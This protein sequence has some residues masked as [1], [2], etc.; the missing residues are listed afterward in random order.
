[1]MLCLF[2]VVLIFGQSLAAQQS[3]AG[4]RG[5]VGD[6]PGAP[7]LPPPAAAGHIRVA[8][9]VSEKLL[10]NSTPPAYPEAAK[11]AHVEG[12]VVLSAVINL[13]GDVET[14]SLLSGHPLL[15]PAALAAV[16]GWKYKPYLRGG[17]PVVIETVVSV[18]FQLPAKPGL[19]TKAEMKTHL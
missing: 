2:V 5:V 8:Q 19:G 18:P 10:I 4:G 16:K 12:E 14:V 15:A 13:K 7:P 11:R 17:K 1:M 9:V 6:Q 3:H